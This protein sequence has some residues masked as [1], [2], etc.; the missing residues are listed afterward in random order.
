MKIIPV[1]QKAWMPALFVGDVEGHA[2]IPD[3][4]APKKGS[5]AHL[6]PFIPPNIIFYEGFIRARTPESAIA[7]VGRLNNHDSGSPR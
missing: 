2:L 4:K 3:L 7:G 6:T 1:P 5:P